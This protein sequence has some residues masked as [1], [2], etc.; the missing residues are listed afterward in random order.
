[1]SEA[2]IR[3]RL[4][5]ES[6]NA[7]VCRI[8]VTAGTSV[9]PLHES[10]Y[11]LTSLRFDDGERITPVRLVSTES[12]DATHCGDWRSAK[13]K[14]TCAIQGDTALRLAPE[15][16]EGGVLMIEGYRTPI[17][18]MALEDSDTATP[19]IHRDHHRHLIDW[20]LHM[21]FA[22]PDMESFDPSRSAMAE[23]QF[24]RYFGARPDADMRRITREDTPHTVKAYWV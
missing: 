15:P 2:C 5:H 21:G 10:L 11:E 16:T 12:L 6:A 17:E 8:F 3:G 18:P 1:M 13:G 9:Y 23:E 4:L 7:D 14:P 20:A 24:T 22:I 19:E